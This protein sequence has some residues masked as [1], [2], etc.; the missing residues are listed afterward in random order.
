MHIVGILC[1]ALHIWIRALDILVWGVDVL[2]KG[3]IQGPIMGSYS[4]SGWS[5]NL[6]LKILW[7]YQVFQTKMSYFSLTIF[8]KFLK[9]F[10]WKS[11]KISLNLWYISHFSD[12]VEVFSDWI[13]RCRTYWKTSYFLKMCEN[14]RFCKFISLLFVYFHLWSRKHWI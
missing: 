2:W 3:N 8:W 7:L 9:I 10:L 14:H 6:K 1:R 11:S 12:K 13:K 4:I 5:L